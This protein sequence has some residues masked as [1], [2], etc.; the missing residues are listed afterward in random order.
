MSV[1]QKRRGRVGRTFQ[2]KGDERRRCVVLGWLL[3]AKRQTS[4]WEGHL[5]AG[6][7]TAGFAQVALWCR[8]ALSTQ[9]VEC[10]D[11]ANFEMGQKRESQMLQTPALTPL[12][13][14]RKPPALLFRCQRR[15]DRARAAP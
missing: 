7:G 5:G 6:D 9:R 2:N 8:S 11:A 15:P 12:T 13:G 3:E 10:Q 14:F 1:A 4:I